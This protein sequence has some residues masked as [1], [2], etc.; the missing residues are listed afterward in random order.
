MILS[1]HHVN[2]M[3]AAS[4]LEAL[5]REVMQMEQEV[6]ELRVVTSRPWVNSIQVR[7]H[8]SLDEMD[9]VVDRLEQLQN[10]EE[11]SGVPSMV[12]YSVDTSSRPTPA[13]SSS[14]APTSTPGSSSSS[15]SA[16]TQCQEGKEE[17]PMVSRK[18]FTGSLEADEEEVHEARVSSTEN[19][20]HWFDALSET[21]QDSI[22]RTVSADRIAQSI[23]P[24]PPAFSL[25]YQMG[26]EGIAGMQLSKS[27][28]DRLKN[29][30]K[31]KEQVRGERDA[32]YG[33]KSI[34]S[35]DEESDEEGSSSSGGEEN[36]HR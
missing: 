8:A 3:V 30:Q 12:N 26:M 27:A 2:P 14:T 35:T 20:M 11:Q 29:L 32:V 16:P 6:Q 7:V 10:G 17:A 21:D 25:A 15:S 5:A 36:E 33:L 31:S 23:M 1:S 34:D 28:K 13:S 18:E 19:P 9:A 22:V 24:N 4:Q